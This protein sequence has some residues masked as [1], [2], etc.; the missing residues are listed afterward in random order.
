[1]KKKFTK[2]LDV[3]AKTFLALLL[4]MAAGM[5]ALHAQPS[6]GPGVDPNA[7]MLYDFEEGD[8]SNWIWSNPDR[9]EMCSFAL[10]DAEN[11]DPVRFGRYALIVNYDYSNAQDGQTLSINISPGK[12]NAIIPAGSNATRKLGMWIY[13]SPGAHAIWLRPQVAHAVS[14]ANIAVFGREF[15]GMAW[16]GWKYC[17]FDFPPA[18]DNQPLGTE[19]AN[20]SFGFLRLIIT[21]SDAAKR[22]KGFLV[23]DNIRVSN[24]QEDLIPPTANAIQGNG[25]DL[26][27]LTLTTSQA[28]LSATFADNAGG[29]GINYSSVRLAVDGYVFKA[30][31]NGFSVN[32]ATNTVSLAGMNFSNGLH[33]VEVMVEDNFGHIAK[34]SATFTINAMDGI[35]TTVEIVPAG[36]ARVGSII[37]LK[38]NTNDL[39]D[40]KDIGFKL[41]INNVATVAETGAVTFAAS[42]TDGSYKYDPIYGILDITLKNNSTAKEGGTLA[43]INI[44]IPKITNDGQIFRCSPVSGIVTYGDDSFSTFTFSP[45]EERVV[46]DYVYRVVKRVVGASGEVLVTDQSGTP[47][48]GVTV[49]VLNMD[50]SSLESAETGANGIAT[51][52][53]T[54]TATERTVYIYVE[55]EG[56]YSFTKNVASLNPLLTSAP[57]YIKA[58]V[59]PDPT[60]SKTI[61]WMSNPLTST[62]PALMKLAKKSEGE[63]SFQQHEGEVRYSEFDASSKGAL[64]GSAVTVKNLD[65]GTT[66]IY[67]V[68]DG[69]TWSATR[70]FTTTTTTVNKFSFAAFGDLQATSNGFM[71]RF[72]AAAKTVE[73][74]PNHLFNLNVGDIVDTDDRYDYFSYYGHLFNEQVGF[75]NYDMIG[76]YGNHEYMGGGDNIIFYNAHPSYPQENLGLTGVYDT[77]MLGVSYATVYGNAIVIGLDWEHRGGSYTAIM[78]ETA[79]WMDEV[80][81]KNNKTWKI[82]ALH[83]PIYPGNSTP[84][85]QAIF[86][87]IFDKHNVQIVFCGHGHTFE[88]VQFRNGEYLA[89]SG[90]NRRTFKP[91]I[92]GTLHWQ[93]GDMNPASTGNNGRWVLCEVDGAKMHVSVRD[94]NNNVVENEGFTFFAAESRF[95]V[96]FRALN[97]GGT[98]T[99]SVDGNTIYSRDEV[100][101]AKDVVFTATLNE[102]TRVK[103]WKVNGVVVAGYTDNVFTLKEIASTTEV[104]VEFTK[105]VYA[106]TFSVVNEEDAGTLTARV[107]GVSINSGDVVE[108]GGQA[109]FT[110]TPNSGYRIKEWKLD[111]ETIEDHTS[112][113]YQLTITADTEVTVEFEAI[114]IVT[115]EVIFSVTGGNGAI[116]A[117]VDDE[118]IATGDQVEHGKNVLFTATPNANYLVKV[119]TLNGAA[120]TG[121]TTNAFTLENL[122]ATATVTVEFEAEDIP[123]VTGSGEDMTANPLKAWIQNGLLHV[124]GL[125]PGAVWSVYD[126]TGALTYQNVATSEEAN[127]PLKVQGVYFVQTGKRVIK[128]VFN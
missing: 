12:N 75:S 57:T 34:K 20:Y 35:A 70:E 54:F 121:A 28:T 69:T 55:K 51:G 40:I 50:M 111:G 3:I 107:A 53:T 113:T 19:T 86:Q 73:E 65:P 67:Q 5:M 102:N 13:G 85:S 23:I 46:A 7:Q 126:V 105:D 1:M 109:N 110:A 49:H 29:S 74:Q 39:S 120:V 125:T 91:D 112:T 108:H 68:G 127:I 24:G 106:V 80:L 93:L 78:T 117:T 16:E 114:P 124:S 61:V 38:L 18:A 104:T 43:T 31:D 17:E 2:K 6:S 128:V 4:C 33:K 116:A 101:I 66:Y 123:P 100:V 97:A 11:G 15:T 9:G 71:S 21:S 10:A 99:A 48:Q 119:W 45:F 87:P 63:G 98:L 83:Y 22:G 47:Q 52:L 118:A 64:K 32:E 89:G 36:E 77:D 41:Q 90:S 42:V 8:I 26:D 94:A 27:G 95:P 56:K 92:G 122:T 79:R 76:T 103:E 84:G 37:G 72:I 30:G 62:G 81:S 59:A 88:R 115:Y 14:G 82:V 96:S 25:S 44:E 60:T 58:G